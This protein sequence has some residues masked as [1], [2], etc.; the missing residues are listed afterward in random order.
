MFS[1]DHSQLPS[2]EWT[3][4]REGIR[5]AAIV[6]IQVTDGLDQDGSDKPIMTDFEG[7]ASE[8]SLQTRNDV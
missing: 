3:E 6:I 4:S 7:K 5:E 1:K 8:I 2:L